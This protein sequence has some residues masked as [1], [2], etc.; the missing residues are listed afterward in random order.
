MLLS[1]R[2]RFLLGLSALPLA[3]CGF[4]PVYGTNGS[5]EK[6]RGQISLQDPRDRNSFELVNA[7]EQRIGHTANGAYALTYK[8]ST[9][10]RSLAITDQ[11]EITRYNLIGSVQYELK[12]LQTRKVVHKSTVQNFTSYSATANT[13]STLAAER[14]AYDRL[15]SIL[16]EQITTRLIG[17][18]GTLAP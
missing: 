6:L 9:N 2:R 12:N 4:E 15:M 10:R 3:G 11:A 8:I 5:A 14:D 16:A 7:L 1:N 18:A 13:I 17:I